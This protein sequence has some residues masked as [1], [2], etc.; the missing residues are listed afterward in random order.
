MSPLLTEFI[1][2]SRE[3]LAGIDADLERLARDETTPDLFNQLFR[4]VHTIKGNC[5]LFD[6]QP[7]LALS[8]AAETLLAM[9]RDGEVNFSAA[10]AGELQQSFDVIGNWV[11]YVA[12]HEV[13]P[14]SAAE[15]AQLLAGNIEML[16]PEGAMRRDQPAA[17]A[18]ATQPATW[19]A[20]MPDA[21]RLAAFDAALA[22][23]QD[24]V[25]AIHY[26]PGKGCF[27]SG[28]DP[29]FFVRELPGLAGLHIARQPQVEPL[30]EAFDPF[31][32]QLD[33]WLLST[34]PQAGVQ[35]VLADASG[36]QLGGVTLAQ[37]ALPA[38]PT[39]PSQAL[40]VL[41]EGLQQADA[42]THTPLLRALL[43][44]L[45]DTPVLEPQLINALPWLKSLLAANA[46]RWILPV[47][48]ALQHGVAGADAA[49]D[50]AAATL[51]A[52]PPAIPPAIRT[53]LQQQLNILLADGA[54]SALQSVQ[55]VAL[56]C[57]QRL[58]QPLPVLANWQA[59]AP[60]ARQQLVDAIR[61]L[62]GEQAPAT[63]LASIEDALQQPAKA[64]D[65]LRIGVA[66]LDHAVAQVEELL[67]VRNM[68]LGHV[69]D[70]RDAG[71]KTQ[72]AALSRHLE[73]LHATMR[74]MRMV[75]LQLPFQRLRKL[76]RN[77]AS[78][79]GK[80]V[81]LQ[82]EGE[83]VVADKRIVDA[84]Y[85]PLVHLLRNAF[86]HGVEPAAARTAL[87][88]PAVASVR[89][90]ASVVH[91]QLLLQVADDG[92]GIDVAKVRERAAARNLHTEAALATMSA[93]DIQQLIF[94]PGLSTA[95]SVSEISGRGVGLDA[96]RNAVR[97]AGGDVQVHSEWQRGTTFRVRLPLSL[98]LS[99]ILHIRQQQQW[100]ALPVAQ[101]GE[102]ARCQSRQIRRFKQLET[103]GWRGEVLPLLRLGDLLGMPSLPRGHTMELIALDLPG[104]RCLLEADA[105][106]ETVDTIVRP[107]EGGLAQ[108][109]VYSGS[110]LS[111]SGE[112]VL[113][114]D[115]Q[116]LIAA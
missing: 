12:S 3:M 22:Q 5:S 103:L 26:R 82:L 52:G 73:T 115:M 31:E 51:P 53:V 92:H 102:I 91:D 77:L 56:L 39:V 101:I 74:G 8:H 10:I 62:L 110:A 50:G 71:L 99:R 45:L 105:I 44:P 6:F 25:L 114:L 17:D 63:P 55:R 38:G 2:E 28:E 60:A 47:L 116:E 98:A 54:P 35:Q 24:E 9:L 36:V 41:I 33:I 46:S 66:Q 79:L 94:Q 49:T 16:L 87:G 90:S 58:N 86:D 57:A 97:N 93:L 109:P 106:G 7:M 88:K 23:Q 104:G 70:E 84:L 42:A 32:C 81:E 15:Q 13:M 69:Q 100:F 59:D 27:F 34:A 64:T 83:D 72:I 19:L 65:M 61:Q 75:S 1:V 30:Q 85:D 113:V 111:S 67:I 89:I 21:Q 96:V 107:L 78:S 43:E 14:D 18:P 108:M 40:A 76:G 37:L 68:L 11:E 112:V 20:Q 48:Q 4:A 95:A 29:L 80:Q